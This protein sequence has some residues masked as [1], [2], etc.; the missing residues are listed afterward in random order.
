MRKGLSRFALQRNHP[1][2]KDFSTD[3]LLSVDKTVGS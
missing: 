1:D 3:D 2:S